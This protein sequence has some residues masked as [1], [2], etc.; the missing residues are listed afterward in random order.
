MERHGGLGASGGLG[1][2]RGLGGS[3]VGPQGWVPRFGSQRDVPC[4]LG[5]TWHFT[6]RS[7]PQRDRL[8]DAE[9]G[10][11]ARQHP[12]TGEKMAELL[13]AEHSP[14]SSVCRAAVSVS[15]ALAE[16]PKHPKSGGSGLGRGPRALHGLTM[17]S[18]FMNTSPRCSCALPAEGLALGPQAGCLPPGLAAVWGCHAAPTEPKMTSREP[19]LR[20][21]GFWHHVCI[22]SW[23]RAVRVGCHGLR[24]S[25]QASWRRRGPAGL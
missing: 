5:A 25:W 21:E 6:L 14:L 1:G 16:R 12:Q 18:H 3:G 7:K 9:Q 2:C 19:W 22:G 17:G 23:A 10:W 15:P 24:G 8:E 13:G 4:L 11:R 20:D